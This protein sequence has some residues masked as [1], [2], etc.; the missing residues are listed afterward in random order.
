MYSEL[1]S[2]LQLVPLEPEYVVHSGSAV[3][4]YFC[5]TVTLCCCCRF[6]CLLFC[7][8]HL[9]RLDGDFMGSPCLNVGLLAFG[10]VQICSSSSSSTANWFVW[11]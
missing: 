6:G 8:C 7:I 11:S 4:H 1:H 3:E 5:L 9:N 2:L 10:A